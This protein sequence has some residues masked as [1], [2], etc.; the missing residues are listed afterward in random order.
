MKRRRGNGNSTF[1]RLSTYVPNFEVLEDRTVMTQFAFTR[2]IDTSALI[3]E[4]IGTFTSF[5]VGEGNGGKNHGSSSS[6]VFL[7]KGSAGQVGLYLFKDGTINRVV[8]RTMTIPGTNSLFNLG[9]GLSPPEYSM[10]GDNVVFTDRDTLAYRSKALYQSDGTSIQTLFDMSSMTPQGYQYFGFTFPMAINGDLFFTGSY[11]IR[12]GVDRQGIW[13]RRDGVTTQLVDQTVTIQNEPSPAALTTTP[14]YYSY[15]GT[16]L[17]LTSS[18]VAG[19]FPNTVNSEGVMVL[20]EGQLVVV[21]NENTTIPAGHSQFADLSGTPAID[22]GVISFYGDNDNT[23]I[24]G[25]STEYGLFSSVV[26]SSSLAVIANQDTII[27]DRFE[28]FSGF[29]RV[30]LAADGKIVFSGFDSTNAHGLYLYDG[31]NIYK[32]IDNTIPLDGKTISPFSLTASNALLNGDILYFRTV[33]TDGTQAI[34]RTSLSEK[35]DIAMQSARLL[36]ANTVQLKYETSGNAGAFDLG[37]YRS[38]SHFT[39]DSTDRIPVT[40]F[41]ATPDPA[42]G[43]RTMIFTLPTGLAAYNIQKPFIHVVA[44]PPLNGNPNGV[45][46]EVDETNN[47]AL[48]KMWDANPEVV[49]PV[50]VE[51][52]VQLRLDK[53]AAIHYQ[54]S[55]KV[56]II[57]SWLRTPE[58]QAELMFNVL[59]GKKGEDDLRKKYEPSAMLEEIIAAYKNANESERLDAMTAKIKEQVAQGRYISFH[60]TGRAIDLRSKDKLGAKLQDLKMALNF[61]IGVELLDETKDK[62]G[63]KKIGEHYHLEFY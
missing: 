59:S 14:L 62:D 18:Y 46:N 53:I 50:N 17:V 1:S 63:N 35:A 60:L 21:A 2:L 47:N 11:I 40:D 41:K 5:G 32:I 33:F 51:Q 39:Y 31:H 57:T 8:D 3:P 45:I 52:D 37:L 20:V 58:K 22:N 4:G 44:D 28:A 9:G 55:S 54:I 10:D 43:Q 19:P 24:P 26:G 6:L 30:I 23:S 25:L 36:D 49:I 13:H 15:D 38:A 42:G 12:P 56:L 27:P 7:G 48:V 61:V 29:D 16:S 34:Y